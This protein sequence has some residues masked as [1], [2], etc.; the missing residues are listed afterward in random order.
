M[1]LDEAKERVRIPEL[2]REFGY[3]GEPKKQCRCPFHEDSTASFSVYDDGKGWKCFSG[4]GNG[5]VIDFL[6]KEK[7]LSD[8]EACKEI[9]RRAEGHHEPVRQE[10]PR[11]EQSKIELPQEIPY[12]SE[13]AQRVADSRGLRITSIEFA[14][15]WLKTLTFG[16]VCD[17]DCWIL[18]DAS[19]NCAEARRI[20]RKPFPAIGTLGERKSHS[21][22]GSSKSWSVGIHPPGF[23]EPWLRDHV[24]RILLVEGGPDYL[25]ACQIIAEQDG[26]VLPVAMLGAT[27]SISQ[28]ALPH[29]TARRVIII[30]HPDK[31]GRAAAAN[32]G[33]QIQGAG[34]LVHAIQL[35]Q[36]DLCDSVAAGKTYDDIN[37]N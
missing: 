12:S 3:E 8:E 29:F 7:G 15:I 13:L 32:W 18:S 11:Q 14:A 33:T 19:R 5:S 2:W 6:A 10:R 37:R 27:Q 28:G 17:Q 21:L 22:R 16:R 26:N 9:L 30:G 34:G 1:T 24:H 36:G 31:S 23:D 4:C 20:D 25:A 35:K